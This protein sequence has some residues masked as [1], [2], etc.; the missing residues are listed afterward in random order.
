MLSVAGNRFTA[1]RASIEVGLTGEP[2]VATGEAARA[3]RGT[4]LDARAWL[5]L[6][7]WIDPVVR[8]PIDDPD[9]PVPYGLVSTLPG[10]CSSDPSR[11]R[12]GAAAMAAHA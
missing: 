10:I 8:V 12:A 5:V 11:L 9:D 2:A 6:R 3:A 1:G 4:D 7:G